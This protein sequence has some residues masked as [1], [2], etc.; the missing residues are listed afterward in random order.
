MF[1]IMVHFPVCHN[2]LSQ[3]A[4]VLSFYLYVFFL[5]MDIAIILS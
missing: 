5:N 4:T 2:T 3:G 1:Q